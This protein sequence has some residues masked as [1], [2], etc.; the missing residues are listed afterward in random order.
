MSERLS[1]SEFARREGCDEKQVRRALERGAL[2]RGDDGLIDAA[3]IGSASR[4]PNRRTLMKTA[5]RP[6]RIGDTNAPLRNGGTHMEPGNA[7][8]QD[9]DAFPRMLPLAEALRL[10]EHYAALLR[11]LEYEQREG[12]LIELA[13]AEDVVFNLFRAQRDAWLAWPSKV[14]PFI[15]AELGVEV[16]RV[17]TLLGEHVWQQLSE[18]GEPQPD[19]SG[20]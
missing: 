18:L 16:D 13:L 15:A 9:I 20:G 10:K 19:F 6:E 14:A 7:A 5:P 2:V 1:A 4:K 12:S 17:A 11:K 8:G 3:L